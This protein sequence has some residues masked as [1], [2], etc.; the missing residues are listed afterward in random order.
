M[1]TEVRARHEAESAALQQL[2]ADAAQQDTPGEFSNA[3]ACRLTLE[4]GRLHSW[5][6]VS[7]DRAGSQLSL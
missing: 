7:R 5:S 2:F 3:F 4:V 1:T 6:S